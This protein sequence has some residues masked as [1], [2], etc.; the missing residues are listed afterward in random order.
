MK[1]VKLFATDFDGTFY[2]YPNGVTEE[3]LETVCKFRKKGNLFGIITGR[4]Y[5]NTDDI[6]KKYSEYCDFIMCMTG[7]YAEGADGK[8]IFE[9][10][11]DG[12]VLFPILKAI[13]ETDCRYLVYSDGKCSYEIDT[14]VPLEEGTETYFEIMRHSSFSQINTSYA[15]REDFDACVKMLL[16][17]YG[18]KISVHA[19]GLCLDIPPAGV[20]KAAAVGRMAEY[21][22]VRKDNIYTAGDNDNDLSMIKAYHGFT[23]PYGTELCRK[24]AENILDGVREMLEMIMN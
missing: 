16:E 21:F 8:V 2:Q 23:L 15:T 1:D 10:K 4:S 3:C 19:N 9:S 6:R 11:G 5:Q 24:S 13:S 17:S 14:S 18:D 12:K 22:G 7:A 20:S